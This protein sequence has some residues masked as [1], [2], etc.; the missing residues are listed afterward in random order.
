MASPSD[1]V[2]RGKIL[3]IVE[4]NVVVF[5]PTGTSYELHLVNQGPEA[6]APTANSVGCYIRASGRKIWTVPSGGNFVVPIF[7]PPRIVQGR[8]RYL[9]ENVMIVHAATPI[10][11]SLPT[12][13]D[14]YD[15]INGPVTLGALVNATLMPGATFE[16]AGVAAAR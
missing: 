5:N 15:L 1:F 12:D 3:R 9:D 4:G 6:V 11:V 13:H 16:L 2:A 8:V 10:H 14:A 7:G